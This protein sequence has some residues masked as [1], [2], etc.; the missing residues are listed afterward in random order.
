MA[1]TST[2]VSGTFASGIG[3]PFREDSDGGAAL[4]DGENY[5]QNLVVVAMQAN[6]SDNPFQ[7][8]GVTNFAVFKPSADPAW[9]LVMRRRIL[10]QIALLERDNLARFVRIDFNDGN[11]NGETLVEVTYLNLETQRENTFTA[12]ITPTRDVGL[13]P[14]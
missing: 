10:T 14:L 7:D 4:A 13:R 8:L 12:A 1:R 5:V 11:G 3:L 9:R 2:K 6:E